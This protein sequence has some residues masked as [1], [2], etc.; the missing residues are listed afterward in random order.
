MSARVVLADD[1]E[2][3]RQGLARAIGD[4]PRL[5]LVAEVADGAAAVEAVT[6]L[7][8][9]LAVLDVRMPGVDGFAACERIASSGSTRVVLITD[10]P[11]EPL[12]SLAASLGAAALLDKSSSRVALCTRLKEIAYDL[13]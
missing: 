10:A 6:R 8:P 9:E 1:H 11:S 5:E 7:R 2:P 13:V 4:D 12:R 3:Y